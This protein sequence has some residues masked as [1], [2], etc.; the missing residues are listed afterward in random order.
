MIE[1]KYW[2]LFFLFNFLVF[3]PNTILRY[4][5]KVWIP[6]RNITR[7]RR[8]GVFLDTDADFY[9]ICLDLC[10]LMLLIRVF[11]WHWFISAAIAVYYGFILIFNIYHYSFLKIYQVSPILS[12]DLRLLKNA[13]AILWAES[14]GKLLIY[15]VGLLSIVSACVLGMYN[16]LCFASSISVENPFLIITGSLFSFVAVGFYRKGIYTERLDT[17]YRILVMFLRVGYNLRRSGLLQRR[18]EHLGKLKLQKGIRLNLKKKPNV[19]F[20]FVESYGEMLMKDE[21]LRA[22]FLQHFNEKK[23]RLCDDGWH[24]YSNLSESISMVGPSWLAYTTVLCG[25]KVNSNFEYEYILNHT[26]KHDLESISGILAKEGYSIYNINDSKRMKGVDIPFQQMEYFFGV[27]HWILKEDINFTGTNYGFM[28]SSPDQYVLNYS[29]EKIRQQET[30]PYFLFYL[31]KNSHTPFISP[32]EIVSDWRSLDNGKNELI[33][34]QFLR[35][36]NKHDYLAAIKYQWDMLHDF[37]RKNGTTDDIFVLYGDHQPHDL[38]DLEKHGKHTL[39]HVIGKDKDFV[40]HFQSYG[41]NEKLE[42]LDK[43]IKHEAFFTAFL[44]SFS[45]HYGEPIPNFDYK[46]N[47]WHL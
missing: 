25:L 26:D 1:L 23:E 9:R 17:S 41:F 47:G 33:G 39:V 31:T 5:P 43:P 37:I 2:S 4:E 40:E 12:N 20:L 27:D 11:H 6:F 19:F 32:E 34:Y 42:E 8:R 24:C 21:M 7:N 35:K 30:N 16:F 22:P 3:V 10:V 14:K 38:A 44:K 13:V 29:L 45:K 15:S 28:E 36:P 18:I 46:P